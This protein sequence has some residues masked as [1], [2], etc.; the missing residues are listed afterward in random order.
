M[1]TTALLIGLALTTTA[2]AHFVFLIDGVGDVRIIFSDALAPDDAVPIEKV[3][4]TKAFARVGGKATPLEL[5]KVKDANAYRVKVPAGEVDAIYA[6]TDYGVLAK[7]DAKPFLL[8]YHSKAV[9]GILGQ[10]VKNVGE[11]L[12]VELAVKLEG[13]KASFQLLAGG[14]AVPEAEVTILHERLPTAKATSGKDG[15]TPAIDVDV[16]RYGV[17]AKH[18]TAKA[19][20]VDGMK[21]DEVRDYA[22]VTFYVG[23]PAP[24]GK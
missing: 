9:P 20:E 22:T 15:W 24:K 21:Y 2:S 18:A 23:K 14:K 13:R 5:E 11:P 7:G 4:R 8:R 19:G 10:P 12:P 17:V 1:R 3:A 6:S 16:G